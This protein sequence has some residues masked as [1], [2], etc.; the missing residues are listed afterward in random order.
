MLDSALP[1]EVWFDEDD[2]IGI[3]LLFHG[4]AVYI[5]EDMTAWTV[6]K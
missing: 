3:I 4:N 2:N 6:V 1:L 5:F